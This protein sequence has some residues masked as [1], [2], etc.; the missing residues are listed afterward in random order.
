MFEF[1]QGPIRPP[2]EAKSLLIRATRNC[3]WNR[4][5]FCHT[6]KGQKFQI[7]SVDEIKEDIQR[8]RDIADEI[9]ELSR[10]KGCGGEVND[11]VVRTVFDR[12]S[13]YSDSYRSVASWLYFGAAQA[14]IQDANSLQMK[15]EDLVAVLTYLTEKFPTINRITSYA[16]SKSLAR[17]TVEELKALYKAGLS[18]I[19]VGLETGYDPLLTYIRKGVTAKEHVEAGKKVVKS[20][21][22]LSEYVMPGLGGKKWTREHAIETAKVLN[23]INPHYI[24]LR[25]LIV[26]S[27][28]ALYHKAQS[29]EM[30][31]L[32]DDEVVHEIG[33]F[34]EHLNG[35]QS[36]LASDH[37]LNLLEEVEGQFPQDKDK[38]LAVIDRYASLPAQERLIF[39]VGRR[40][41]LYRRL[42]D[43]RDEATRVRVEQAISRL[44]DQGS[45]NVE[46][47]LKSMMANY[48]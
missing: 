47:T 26:R 39:K 42:D 46:E 4:C 31:V 29:G 28:M 23:Q 18:R 13:G 36:Y 48:I 37:I 2:S 33:L 32:G 45:G 24:R 43:L 6:Y 9:G 27:D 5:E 38:L 15:T 21:I 17:K 14:F 41:G 3:P 19:H 12:Y 22:S 8:A 7:R 10:R 11:E 16:R 44:N 40:A 25:T 35:I 1:E 30:E 20:G 34:I